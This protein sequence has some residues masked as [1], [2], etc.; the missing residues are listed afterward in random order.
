MEV[1]NREFVSE[2]LGGDKKWGK[3]EIRGK[4]WKVRVREGVGVRVKNVNGKK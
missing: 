1:R 2:E 4:E 3:V